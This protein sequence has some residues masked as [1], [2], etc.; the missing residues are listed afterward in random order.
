MCKT[1]ATMIT[2]CFV[3]I[4]IYGVQLKPTAL[5]DQELSGIVGGQTPELWCWPITG[6]DAT[7][8]EC[9][10]N[11]EEACLELNENE[12]CGVG[13]TYYQ[14]PEVCQAGF[15]N[16]TCDESPG[17]P[18]KVICNEKYDCTCQFEGGTLICTTNEFQG[19]ECNS[20]YNIN[21]GGEE[22][23]AEDA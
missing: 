13:T 9:E 10:S 12:A 2:A 3:S 17:V 19:Y 21:C 22:C 7:D 18:P 1:L 16:E 5:K 15:G 23:P 20:G 8:I 6:C 4:A 11:G 14:Y